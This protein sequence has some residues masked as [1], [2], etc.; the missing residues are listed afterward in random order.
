MFA[1]PILDFG[2]YKVELGKVPTHIF[3]VLAFGAQ[4]DDVADDTES[5]Q[6]ALDAVP[7][8]GAIVYCPKRHL[9]SSPLKVRKSGTVLMGPG[10]TAGGIRA[11]TDIN[12][13][14]VA[15]N[16]ISDTIRYVRITGLKLQGFNADG[17]GHNVHF[18]DAI[19]CVVDNCFIT[20]APDHGVFFDQVTG[21]GYTHNVNIIACTITGSH[22]WGVRSEAHRTSI[23]HSR[24]QGNTTGGIYSTRS[25]LS[26]VGCDVEGNGQGADGEC[27]ILMD[28][29]EPGLFVAGCYFESNNPTN[30][31]IG[32][33]Y[34]VW[35]T[36]ITGCRFYT[37]AT[38]QRH[39]WAK[40]AAGL[41]IQGNMF[42]NAQVA[43]IRL[44][45]HNPGVNP[46]GCKNV[47]LQGNVFDGNVADISDA[48]T[49]AGTLVNQANDTG[50]V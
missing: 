48:G 3:N 38:T 35:G 21:S 44:E 5:I 43:A 33:S 29:G 17:V 14:E 28:N 10:M 30:I 8:G 50:L 22:G 34:D 15:A 4:G 26:V 46:K 39:I 47:V 9:I 13:I 40:G 36:Q 37:G 1:N 23:S 45:A 6:A 7:D 24:I 12:L 25:T 42:F 32:P 18:Q 2:G 20:G 19:E 27:G 49:K 31:L 41:V 16:P 11:I